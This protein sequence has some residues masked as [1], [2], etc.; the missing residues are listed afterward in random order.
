MRFNPKKTGIIAL[1]LV[2]SL[3]VVFPVQMVEAQTTTV[4]V[5]PQNSTPVVGRTITISILLNNV[6]NLYGIDVSL[7]WDTSLLSFQANSNQ[8]FLGVS[9]GMLNPPPS[10]ISVVLDSASQATGNSILSQL[11]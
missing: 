6:A 4:T 11:P 3:L 7:T 10:S 2:A 1:L 8:T 9:S 5:S